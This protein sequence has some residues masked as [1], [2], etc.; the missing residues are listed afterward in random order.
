MKFPLIAVLLLLLT[1][2]NNAEKH[3]SMSMPGAYK[4]LYQKVKGGTTDTTFTALQ[5][6]KIYTDEYMMY[7]NF[8][9]SDSVSN[10]GIGTYIIKPD[11]AISGAKTD[12]VTE[13]VFYNGNDT[14]KSETLHHFKLLIEKTGVGYK[15]IIPGIESDSV[16]FTLTED[17]ENVGTQVTT[18]LDGAWKMEKEFIVKG[19][20]TTVV[21][22]TQFKVYY[23]GHFIWG[24]TYEDA[25]KKTHTG[26]GFGTFTLS[27]TDKLK[28]SVTV[29]TYAGARNHDFDIALEMNGTDSFKQTI[30][31]DSS[32]Q[33]ETY[34]RLKR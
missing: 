27:G 8:N 32:K 9:P 6:Q 28:E 13:H 10:F 12:T 24:H 31:T 25:A 33:V 7:A 23:A 22:A 5:Q 20:D 2:C 29:S 4:M 15:Q 30:T 14:T 34:T 17:Y 21:A 19:K 3:E 26:I 11:I 16:K 1:A 18:P